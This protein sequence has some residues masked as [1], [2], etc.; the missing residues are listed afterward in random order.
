LDGY[1]QF[2]YEITGPQVTG[3]NGNVAVIPEQTFTGFTGDFLPVLSPNLGGNALTVALN[4]SSSIE[5]NL[6][7]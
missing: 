6:T 5:F 2:I 7:A 4:G 3:S 1:G